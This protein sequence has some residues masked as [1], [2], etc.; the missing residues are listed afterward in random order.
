MV[1][2][3]RPCTNKVLEPEYINQISKVA[4]TCH[5]YLIQVCHRLLKDF[6]SFWGEILKYYL[7]KF[8]SPRGKMRDRKG[9]Y[10]LIA[11]VV[12]AFDFFSG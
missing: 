4:K 8:W 10:D 1:I 2:T 3:L 11:V 12:G 5:S 6:L 7:P 9:A